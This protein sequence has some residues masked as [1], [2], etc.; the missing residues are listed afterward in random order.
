MGAYY[1]CPLSGLGL[2]V[3]RIRAPLRFTSSERRLWRFHFSFREDSC[4]KHV[5]LT[6]YNEVLFEYELKN[7]KSKPLEL[8][9]AKRVG[10]AR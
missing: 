10:Y 1:V 4:S 3:P 7:P 6:C 2:Y 8:R 5:S 9:E